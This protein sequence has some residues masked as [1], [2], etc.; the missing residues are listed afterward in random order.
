MA[1]WRRK[2]LELFPELRN[3][4]NSNKYAPYNLFVELLPKLL[5]WVGV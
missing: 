4:L 2:A 3:D 1:V 5:A